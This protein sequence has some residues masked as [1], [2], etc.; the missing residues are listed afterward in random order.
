[1]GSSLNAY[2]CWFASANQRRPTGPSITAALSRYA[3]S[4]PRELFAYVLLDHGEQRLRLALAVDDPVGVENL[5]PAV[6]GV[7]LREHHQFDVGRDRG[8]SFCEVVGEVVDLVRRQRQAE[9]L[10]RLHQRLTA[11]RQQR[12]RVR[13]GAATGDRTIEPRRRRRTRR[14]RSSGRRAPAPC[15]SRSAFDGGLRAPHEIGDAPL[16]A[17]DGLQPAHLRDVGGLA[18]PGRNRARPRRCTTIS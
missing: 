16:D 1:M 15:A 10:V 8:P 13:G 6:L 17:L 11:A 2:V 14:L 4:T 12:H 18:G 9:R 5:V 3:D 7:R